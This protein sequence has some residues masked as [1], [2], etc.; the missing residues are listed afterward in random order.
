MGT[1]FVQF[2]TYNDPI[3]ERKKTHQCTLGKP[4][5][6]ERRTAVSAK[7]ADFGFGWKMA[8]QDGLEPPTR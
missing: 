8:P 3:A 7:V 4:A 1:F 6:F 5:G 2:P